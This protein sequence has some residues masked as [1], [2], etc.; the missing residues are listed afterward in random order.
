MLNDRK[1]I[2]MISNR[3]LELILLP[4]EQC[5]FRCTY[6]YEDFSIGKMKKNIVEA[7][8]KLILQRIDTLDVLQIGWFG[9]EPLAA[10]DIVYDIS[11]YVQQLRM[12][13]PNV[14]Y[15]S[16]MTTNGFQL[17]EDI[18]RKL[19]SLD[20]KSFQVS[21]DGTEKMHNLTRLRLNGSGSFNTI[22]HNL[23]SAK[24]TDIDFSITL[25]IHITPDNVDDM[26][27]LIDLIKVNFGYDP[28]FTVFFKAI[29]TL[30]GPNA[31]TFK[32][33]RGKDKAE[34]LQQLYDY[35]GPAMKVKKLNDNGPYV[36][37]AAK[38]N[39]LVIRADGKIGK[40]TVALSDDRNSLGTLLDDGTLEIAS[41]KLALWTRGISSQNLVEL[42]CPMYQ[43]PTLKSA[44]QSIP[45]VLQG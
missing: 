30:G 17:K 10:K 12:K 32:V 11:S 42:S 21:L 44:L 6:C 35:L 20:V 23:L 14:Q 34:I 26:Y 18:F 41:D 39:S 29:E 43:L 27:E 19:I 40:C 22:W 2:S 33:I 13:Y 45:V 36:C 1:I 25:R 31:G 24:N 7:I 3:S 8:K 16:N 9:G 38:T 28:R 15:L 4:T 5:N 37:Y